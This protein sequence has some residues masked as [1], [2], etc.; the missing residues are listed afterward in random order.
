MAG[1]IE[2]ATMYVP[3][4]ARTDGIPAAV[5]KSLG[6]VV[7]QGDK[8]GESLGS[9]MAAGLGKTFA[10][11]A[12]TAAAAG[13]VA[14]GTALTKG[15]QRLTAIDDA[16]GKLEGLGH[17]S[18][19]TAKIMDSALA[20]VKGTAFGLGEAAT[21]SASAVAAGIKPG[22]DLT[23]YLSI[24]ADAATIA[25]TSI[26]EMG[27]VMNKVQ[28]KGKAYTLDLNQLAIRGIP[29]YQMLAKEMGVSQEALTDMV[30]AGQVDSATYLRAIE[31]NLGGAARAGN[32][33][34]AAWSNTMAAMGRVGAA[35]LKPTFSRSADWLKGVTGGIDTITPKVQAFAEMLD[36]RIFNMALPKLKEFGEAG[37]EAFSAFMDDNGGAIGNNWDRF[38]AAL[39][40]IWETAKNLGAPL[41]AIASSLAAAQAALGVGVWSVFLSLLES[42]SSI[43]DATLVPV[44]NGL[45]SVMG[46][47]Q[48]AVVALAGAFMLF[49]TIPAL[50]ARI[51]PSMATL[52]AAS[53]KTA[54]GV[55]AG[56]GGLTRYQS[57]LLS[58][59]TAISGTV[60]G[61]RGFGD[62]MR[63]QQSLAAASGTTVGRLG[64]AM[65]SMQAQ[66]PAIGRMGDAYRSATPGLT[67]F[68]SSHRTAAAEMKA[69]ALQ[70][71]GFTSTD[72]IVRQG[73]HGTAAAIGRLGS[74]AGGIGAAGMSAMGSAVGGL[75]KGFGS[76]VGALGGPVGASILAAALI[77]PQVISAAKN[78]DAQADISAKTT[79]KLTE[80]QRKMARAFTQSKGAVDDT[81]LSEATKQ[82]DALIGKLEQ[83]EDAK[84]G[85]FSRPVEAWKNLTGTFSGEYQSGTKEADA[86]R[87]AAARAGAAR[88][89][90][91]EL[92]IGAEEFGQALSGTTVEWRNFYDSALASG[93]VTSETAGEWHF[94]RARLESVRDAA[95]RV[96]PGIYE[97]AEGFK[98]LGDAAS[99]TSQKASAFKS[100]MDAIAGVPPDLGN[101]MS[102][103][104]QVIREAKK[105]IEEPWD[106]SKGALG[107]ALIDKT[108]GMVN[109]ATENG[110]QVRG[111]IQGITRESIQLVSA[112]GNVNEVVG[113][114]A[115]RFKELAES[116][117]L[118]DVQMSGLLEKEGYLER[119][120]YAGAALQGLDD[121]AQGIGM[122][123]AVLDEL[124]P[125][126]PKEIPI[127]LLNDEKVRAKL[128]SLGVAIKET[129][130][131]LNYKLTM[132]DQASEKM[133]AVVGEAE[134]LRDLK[135]VVKI[136][137]DTGQLKI[138]TGEA[139]GLIDF[140]AEQKPA[141]G[142]TLNLDELKKNKTITIQ[143]IE[144][145]SKKVANP[146][147]LLEGIPKFITDAAQAKAAL[148]EL[149]DRTV[150]VTMTA[151]NAGITAGLGVSGNWLGSRLPRNSTGSRLPTTGPGTGTRDGI[152]GIGSDGIPTSWVDK[153]E[154]IVNGRSSEKWNWLL[155]MINR[156]DSRLEN[157]PRF[158]E[159]G[160]NG[161][162]KALDAG[163]SVSGNKYLW[164]G[165]GPTQFDCSGFVGWLQQIVMGIT[166]SVKRLYTTYDFFNGGGGVAGLQ[167][168]LGPSGTAFQV[169]VS[170]EHM[171][172]TI[173]GQP[174]ESGGSMG[175]SGIGP[176]WA[177]ATHPQFSRHFHLPNAL[178]DG[179]DGVTRSYGPD[180]DPWT[181]KDALAL[182]SARVAVIQAKE[183][184][185][186]I[187]G[188]DKKS[189]ADRD[190]ANLKVQ[191]AELKVRDL[192][193]KRDGKG[194]ASA[195]SGEPAP[196]LSGEMG[197][198]A[199]SL[200]NAEI[201]VIDAQ[202]SRDKVYNDPESTSL[203]KEKADISVYSAQN[204]LAQARKKAEEEEAD[205]GGGEFSLKDR[206]K[207]YGSD[208]VG[209]AVDSALEI[210]GINSRWLD[211]PIP[212]FKTPKPGS[213]L[214][215]TSAA[216]SLRNP[217]G[218]FP[219]RSFPQSELDNQLPVTIGAKNWAEDWLKS[220]PIKLYDQGGMIPHGGLALNKSG[221]PEPVFTNA[222]FANI[223]R[224]ANLDTVAVGPNAGGGNDYSININNP[225]FSDGMAAVNSAQRAQGRQM[226]RHA[227]RP[228]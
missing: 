181:E 6:K 159:G 31:K 125:G 169:G 93:K 130:D 97:I 135:A 140:I 107:G 108:T 217:L 152:L 213:T 24:T 193:A 5:S 111:I 136:D 23:R 71:R 164:G 20:S 155:G 203:D 146:K 101:A 115:E 73:V 183:A 132:D 58:T 196:P 86:S 10:V 59:R 222:E 88:A 56:A 74:V 119:I 102:S 113:S 173:D 162:D 112:G 92:G 55:A 106:L 197:E 126:E 175:S 168:G 69:L 91:K 50:M 187:H 35:A 49:K 12:A 87:E 94:A 218:D 215:D 185:D 96:T 171:A 182:E 188:N 14:V 201:S 17:T 192:E 219:T 45:A 82:A 225:T 123:K 128:E 26:E 43:L 154:W 53:V 166:G 180:V 38:K 54:A 207:K 118:T 223:A 60:T 117:N 199:I 34:S 98:V 9:R 52:Q 85:F 46:N 170:K 147:A 206:L 179:W 211:I 76:I 122:V 42:A 13:S 21:I 80:S 124:K 44:L 61:L 143:D 18:L 100:V 210:F 153:G 84:P 48:G 224:I 190:Q 64:A 165:T 104:N 116:V 15:F 51:A 41:M 133:A 228:Y 81:I 29:I 204:S 205:N 39:S 200:R 172:A 16:E 150:R 138:K 105:L 25:G 139:K 8:A 212:E 137:A 208:L 176:Q 158:Y 167:P 32:T 65:A 194:S 22:N 66:A 33:V 202:L 216:E 198:A 156:D 72:A 89:A 110:E 151:V 191:R 144:E 178:I 70:S 109:T 78:W 209:I 174:A 95:K 134:A 141:P 131:G 142:V 37:K 145:L 28:T 127:E 195:M 4:A 214:P 157:L 83:A 62:Q 184:R 227:G 30:A 177:S 3:I 11:G 114:N 189:Q 121:V 57:A 47:N 220:L 63:V 67:A 221:A 68:A 226:M 149:K 148:A 79:D 99:T 129:P 90:L 161:I 19:S 1:G 7:Q 27:A 120:L 2:L 77:V 160:R 163:R 75:A 40:D 186:K 103:Y 36:H